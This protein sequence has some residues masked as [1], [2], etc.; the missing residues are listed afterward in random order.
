MLGLMSSRDEHQYNYVH[1]ALSD[2]FYELH[3]KTYI[4]CKIVQIILQYHRNKS[5]G[6][7]LRFLDGASPPE[8]SI[9]VSFAPLFV[10]VVI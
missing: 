4:I 5:K 8:A 10:D 9:S 3:T 2:A 1:L 6:L 7:Y